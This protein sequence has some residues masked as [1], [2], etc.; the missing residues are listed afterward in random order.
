[1]SINKQ[2]GKLKDLALKRPTPHMP[3]RYQTV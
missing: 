3:N 2:H 1:M